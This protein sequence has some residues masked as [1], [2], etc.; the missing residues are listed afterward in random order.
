MTNTLT[1][2]RSAVTHSARVK[3]VS[4]AMLLRCRPTV[5]ELGNVSAASVAEGASALDD[6]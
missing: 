4:P 3:K 5:G 2:M 6:Q 1:L